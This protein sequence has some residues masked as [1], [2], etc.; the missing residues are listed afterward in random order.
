MNNLKKLADRLAQK[1]DL[2]PVMEKDIV[3]LKEKILGYG[4]VIEQ[5]DTGIQVKAMSPNHNTIQLNNFSIQV[6]KVTSQNISIIIKKIMNNVYTE[7]YIKFFI[8]SRL[9]SK[10]KKV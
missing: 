4:I 1:L 8:K 6:K 3:I 10:F 7:D 5:E 9:Q 2:T